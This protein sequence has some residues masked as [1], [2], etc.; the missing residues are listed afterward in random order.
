MCWAP[1]IV[2]DRESKSPAVRR[3]VA[4]IR[5]NGILRRHVLAEDEHRTD[6]D[7]VQVVIGRYEHERGVPLIDPNE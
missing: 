3:F 1:S 4:R 6:H 5:L 2:D 7:L